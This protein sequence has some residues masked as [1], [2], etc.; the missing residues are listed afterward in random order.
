VQI[1]FQFRA[2]ALKTACLAAYASFSLFFQTGEVYCDPAASA[3]PEGFKS[4]ARLIA[5]GGPPDPFY[6]AGV[7]LRLAPGSLTYWRTPGSA[8]APPVFSFDA[9]SNIAELKVLYPGPSR[10]EEGDGGEAFG[11]RE[12][13]VFPLHVTPKDAASPVLVDLKLS[14]AV[15]A[16]ICLP[17]HTEV[18]LTLD[19][20][21]AAG[22]PEAGEI[23]SAEA[24]VPAP[25][26]ARDAPVTLTRDASAAVP[27]WRLSSQKAIEDIFVE[28]SSG[29]YFE[30]KKTGPEE[31]LILAV[32]HPETDGKGSIP[33]TLTLIGAQGNYEFAVDLADAS[34]K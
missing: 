26:P 12:G 34:A 21:A 14:Y 24:A 32:E 20:K 4:S 19:P 5:A 11:Y 27:T 16:K 9:S 7:E 3:W 25:L 33:A 2:L 13:V 31:F 23:A 8:G 1:P 6:R 18:K 10:I 22:L 29:W 15:C 30:T 28:G 17:Q